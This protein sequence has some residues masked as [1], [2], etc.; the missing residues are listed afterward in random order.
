MSRKRLGLHP[1]QLRVL[2]LLNARDVGGQGRMERFNGDLDEQVIRKC[3][4]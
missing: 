1:G 2:G 3:R 4:P